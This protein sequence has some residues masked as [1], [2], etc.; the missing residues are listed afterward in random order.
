MI[1]LLQVHF[2]K[3]RGSSRKMAIML[4]DETWKQKRCRIEKLWGHLSTLG[5][6]FDVGMNA[7][8]G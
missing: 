6:V 3:D 2:E 1:E 4:V 7:G 5:S 8:K